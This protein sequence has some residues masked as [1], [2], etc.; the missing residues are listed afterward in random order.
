[1]RQCPTI[2]ALI[3]LLYDVETRA[4]ECTPERRAELRQQDSQRILQ[5]LR[6]YLDGPEM[7]LPLVLPKSKLAQA[8]NYV[9]NNWEALS[10]FV[11][12]GCIPLDNN[13]TEQLMKQV[14]TG[15]KNWRAPEVPRQYSGRSPP[16]DALL[17]MFA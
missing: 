15:R 6:A 5:Q 12:D 1:V 3:Q 8:A 17:A 10:L 4:K 13:E 9:K 14:A 11:S 16:R 2:L 7:A